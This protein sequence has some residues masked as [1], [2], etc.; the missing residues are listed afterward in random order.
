MGFLAILG[1]QERCLKE[2]REE[3]SFL[4]KKREAQSLPFPFFQSLLGKD[5]LT[6]AYAKDTV[7]R[8]TF[9][10]PIVPKA[11]GFELALR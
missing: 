3:G 4:D 6:R 8:L 5:F 9:L 7:R 2:G 1:S 11:I 10:E